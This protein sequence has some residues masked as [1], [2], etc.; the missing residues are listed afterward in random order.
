MSH[1]RG[2]LHDNPGAT[3]KA[4]FILGSLVAG[5]TYET[6]FFVN[7]SR[8]AFGPGNNETI[9]SGTDST[10]GAGSQT[11]TLVTAS[12]EGGQGQFV[13]GTFVADNSGAASFTL[14]GNNST[15]ANGFQYRDLGAASPAP[16][17]LQV[18]G[19]GFAAFGLVGLLLKA[20][21]RSADT[22]QATR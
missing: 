21:K 7:D 2:S 1:L 22:A 9:T 3:D 17:P 12:A 15:Q 13:V 8:G 16:E 18:A 5:H 10:A 20:R 14:Q 19:L 4:N 6:Q 11:L